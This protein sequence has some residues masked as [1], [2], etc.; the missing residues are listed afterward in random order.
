[1]SVQIFSQIIQTAF[2]HA[3]DA[4]W[5]PDSSARPF[6]RTDVSSHGNFSAKTFQRVDISAHGSLSAAYLL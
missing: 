1:M 4:M 6:Q 3:S 2:S 5:L